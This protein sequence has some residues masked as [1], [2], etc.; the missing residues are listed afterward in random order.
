M[1][2]IE[3]KECNQCPNIDF[4]TDGLPACDLIGDPDLNRGIMADA[5]KI[6]DWCPLPDKEVK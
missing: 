3:I 5:E 2:V 4:T 1:K 6:P